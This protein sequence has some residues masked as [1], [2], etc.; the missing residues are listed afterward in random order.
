MTQR[1]QFKM[2]RLSPWQFWLMGALGVSLTIAM[3]VLAATFFLV[4]APFALAAG[5]YYKLRGHR[6]PPQAPNVIDADYTVVGDPPRDRFKPVTG[7]KP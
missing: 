6:R 3:L 7:P 4:L 1:M 2:M 5:V